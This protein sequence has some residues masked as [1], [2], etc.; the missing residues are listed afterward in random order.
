MYVHVQQ[1]ERTES[2]GEKAPTDSRGTCVFRTA[3]HDREKTVNIVEN[4]NS[5]S[6]AAALIG[7]TCCH[8]AATVLPPVNPADC[9]ALPV[10][11]DEPASAADVVVQTRR[12]KISLL[13]LPQEGEDATVFRDARP[14]R[15][16]RSAARRRRGRGAAAQG[17]FGDEN[18]EMSMTRPGTARI[19]P[20]VDLPG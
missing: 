18:R 20:A 3:V 12:G 13:R 7:S 16:K 1:N 6:N 8:C 9:T 10:A 2:M 17:S 11:K 5:G 14:G 19:R 15:R 4:M